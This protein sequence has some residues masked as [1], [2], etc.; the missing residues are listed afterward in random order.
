[1][2]YSVHGNLDGNLTFIR[3]GNRSLWVKYDTR[4]VLYAP[5]TIAM[6]VRMALTR[7]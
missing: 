4:L 6:A 3:E 7:I 1:M 2:I 5:L